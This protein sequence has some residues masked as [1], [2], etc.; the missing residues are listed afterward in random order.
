MF[1]EVEKLKRKELIEL[2]SLYIENPN[3]PEI[4]EMAYAACWN[5]GSETIFSKEVNIAGPKALK[6]RDKELSIEEAKKILN[7]LI[8]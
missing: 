2:Y 1:D 4:E 5:S 6:M 8:K 7:L 3:N